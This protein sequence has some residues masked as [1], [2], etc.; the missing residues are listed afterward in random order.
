MHRPVRTVR[1]RPGTLE[2][3]IGCTACKRFCTTTGTSDRCSSR[4]QGMSGDVRP[5]QPIETWGRPADGLST[6]ARGAF[7]RG[8]SRSG[9][10]LSSPSCLEGSAPPDK[11]LEERLTCSDQ[12]GIVAKRLAV[13][14]DA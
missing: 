3:R 1:A 5:Q 8:L 2:M 9:T 12:M 4:H 10:L 13:L 6:D 11:V 7:V 14:E